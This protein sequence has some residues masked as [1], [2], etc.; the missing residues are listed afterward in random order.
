MIDL[1]RINVCDILTD[2]IEG[3][4]R[5][6]PM[7]KDMV[8]A[9]GKMPEKCPILENTKLA[10]KMLN[11]DPHTV[12]YMLHMDPKVFPH[13][14]EMIFK[15]ALIFSANNSPNTLAINVTA[16]VLSRRKA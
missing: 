4:S 12:P 6:I 5:I 13:L 11:M 7:F 2:S 1:Q 14:P 16:E 8:A 15:L 10:F 3:N 9:G